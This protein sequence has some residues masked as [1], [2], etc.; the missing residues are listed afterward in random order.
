MASTG[1]STRGWMRFVHW[2]PS[3]TAMAT[4][5]RVLERVVAVLP[6][7]V[8]GQAKQL[9]RGAEKVHP[10]IGTIDEVGFDEHLQV[11]IQRD[12][13]SCGHH[14]TVNPVGEQPAD[15]AMLAQESLDSPLG[16]AVHLAGQ[17]QVHVV[18]VLDAPD[19]VTVGPDRG[20]LRDMPVDDRVAADVD[21]DPGVFGLVRNRD[22]LATDP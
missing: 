16:R 12:G 19:H 3:A 9:V 7:A 20:D 8:G 6:V 22:L 17:H 21:D 5:L 1:I 18:A 13:F 2:S 4:C 15:A 14:L 11:A 10:A